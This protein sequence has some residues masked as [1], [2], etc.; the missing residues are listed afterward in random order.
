MSPVK[1]KITPCLI[2]KL[3][4]YR[5]SHGIHEIVRYPKT[6]D[7]NGRSQYQKMMYSGCY[8]G[9]DCQFSDLFPGFFESSVHRSRKYCENRFFLKNSPNFRELCLQFNGL[10]VV[11]LFDTYFTWL[12]GR[13]GLQMPL[14]AFY[15][16]H[17][18][19]IGIWQGLSGF[20]W[21]SGN[22]FLWRGAHPDF[23]KKVSGNFSHAWKK[24]FTNLFLW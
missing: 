14:V 9:S 11:T 17:V 21:E 3:L 15:C 7:S 8:S 16:D 13:N 4:D 2:I 1:V 12:L 6:G 23:S 10:L 5:P 19:E 18:V 24:Y 22:I 20:F